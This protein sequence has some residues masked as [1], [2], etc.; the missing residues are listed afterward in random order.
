MAVWILALVFAVALA[1]TKRRS[2]QRPSNIDEGIEL[3]AA[4]D[5]TSD[6]ELRAVILHAR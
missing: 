1:V 6:R 4:A 2:A 5:L 3:V